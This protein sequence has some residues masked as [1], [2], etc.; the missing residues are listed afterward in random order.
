MKHP[1]K[2]LE[3]LQYMD[4]VRFAADKFE[5]LGWRSY[6]KQFRIAMSKCT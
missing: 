5:G 1:S 3:L 6:D 2:N 4:K